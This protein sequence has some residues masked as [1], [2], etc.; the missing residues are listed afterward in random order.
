M[1][2][3]IP[4]PLWGGWCGR[5]CRRSHRRMSVESSRH[6]EKDGALSHIPVLPSILL[7]LDLKLIWRERLY[8]S[9]YNEPQKEIRPLCACKKGLLHLC[10]YPSSI[11]P[12]LVTSVMITSVGLPGQGV[13]GALGISRVEVGGAEAT[14]A[15][16]YIPSEPYITCSRHALHGR[17]IAGWVQ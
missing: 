8:P 17:T 5:R 2:L 11:L 15:S 12:L 4:S 14:I 10:F 3:Y 9:V 16:L 6:G 13:C 1:Y 7:R